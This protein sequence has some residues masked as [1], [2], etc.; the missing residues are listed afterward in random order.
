M[1]TNK[2]PLLTATTRRSYSAPRGDVAD[3]ILD[4]ERLSKFEPSVQRVEFVERGRL[5]R[6]YIQGLSDPIEFTIRREADVEGDVSI[7]M[8]AQMPAGLT[9]FNYTVRAAKTATVVDA[10]MSVFLEAEGVDPSAYNDHMTRGLT[11][12]LDRVGILLGEASP[13]DAFATD[14][15]RVTIGRVSVAKPKSLLVGSHYGGQPAWIGEPA[16]PVSR[17]S[18]KPM[19]FLMQFE[20][21]EA[22]RRGG[23]TM[24]YLFMSTEFGEDA[25]HPSEAEGGENAVILQGGAAF[26][27]NC[28]TTNTPAG[29]TLQQGNKH[30]YSSVYD[31]VESSPDAQG[32]I[33]ISPAKPGDEFPEF[34]TLGGEVEWLQ[35]DDTPAGGPWLLLAQ[36]V[37]EH[38]P[39]WVP[40][41]AYLYVFIS[42]DG[43]EAR[44]LY[45][46]T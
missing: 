20:I 12:I 43:R 4:S 14:R 31:Y 36:F 42:R 40:F 45:Q 34:S 24:A 9:M 8:N 10:Q 18:A 33:T 17:S 21:P 15:Y 11:Q 2:I 35:N 3:A 1:A 27:P 29:P 26:E 25:G 7:S 32:P 19:R 22:L 46:F 13:P 37:N 23:H 30:E 39:C 6:V 38:F 5:E 28:I 16:W 41:D 44:V